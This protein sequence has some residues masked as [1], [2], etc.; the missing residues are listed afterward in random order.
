MSRGNTCAL[1]GKALPTDNTL[2]QID[3]IEPKARVGAKALSN[4]HLT[5]A[6]CNRSKSS[7]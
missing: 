6:A 1:C 4:C 2:N 3:R 7:R 5:H